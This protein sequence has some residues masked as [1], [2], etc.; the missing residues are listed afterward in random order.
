M[1]R[2]RAESGRTQRQW[3]RTAAGNDG[4]LVVIPPLPS[5]SAALRPVRA[6]GLRGVGR[7]AYQSQAAPQPGGR[8]PPS[9][10]R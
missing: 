3:G 8:E 1:T 6:A 5:A 9:R 7:A 10:E 4:M 2:R